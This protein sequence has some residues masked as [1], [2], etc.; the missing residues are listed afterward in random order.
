MVHIVP[1]RVLKTDQY[2]TWMD[3]FDR[4]RLHAGGDGHCWNRPLGFSRFPSSTEHL[5]LNEHVSTVHNVRSHKIQ[6]QLNVIHPEIFPQ[7]QTCTTTVTSDWSTRPS[8]LH[9]RQRETRRNLKVPG[10]ALRNLWPPF[11]SPM[12]ELSVS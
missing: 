6:T 2:R 1:E 12:S 5:I 11:R 8:V 9:C 10:F 4:P 7:L 3:R